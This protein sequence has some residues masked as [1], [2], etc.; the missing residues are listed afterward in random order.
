VVDNPIL[1]PLG[2]PTLNGTVISVDM[3]LDMPEYITQRLIDLTLQRFIV[4][5]IF[6]TGGNPVRGGAV[7][8][9]QL[10]TNQLYTTN[11][12]EQVGPTGEFPI[13]SGTRMAPLVAQV[14]KYGGK[15]QYSDEAKRRQDSTLF[16]QLT[17]QLA[18]TIVRKVNVIAV[19]QLDAQI[20]AMAGVTTYAAPKH[21]DLVV[22]N[23]VGVD[24]NNLWP[25]ANFAMVNAMAQGFELGNN[26][27]NLWFLNPIDYATL[28]VIYGTTLA[29][30]LASQGVSIFPSNRVAK[31]SAYAIAKGNVGFLKYE[32]GLSTETWREQKTESTWVQSSVLPVMGI[33]NPY[34]V[35]KITGI[36][37]PAP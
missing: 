10:T 23:G 18:N 26:G 12:V 7:I 13:V 30:L 3:A 27:Y 36:S 33:T 34:S 35:I 2:A 25:A 19:A 29:Q 4:D 1:Y 21:W 6:T 24:P 17:T 5:Q 31:G 11:D 37:T 22:T 8:Y 32:K 9:D 15:F 28:G 16:D 14:A 20:A